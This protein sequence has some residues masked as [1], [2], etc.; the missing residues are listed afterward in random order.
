MIINIDFTRICSTAFITDN[1]DLY[2]SNFLT[3]QLDDAFQHYYYDQSASSQFS[4]DELKQ[5]LISSI[6][7][8]KDSYNID[9]TTDNNIVTL[10]IPDELNT[11][12]E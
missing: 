7:N 10:T 12:W 9:V 11:L 4:L 8:L 6:I 1:T 3:K 2:N 5:I